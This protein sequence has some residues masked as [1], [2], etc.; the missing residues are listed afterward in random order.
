MFIA[1]PVTPGQG[2]ADHVRVSVHRRATMPARV[3]AVVALA[4]GLLLPTSIAQATPPV[5]GAVVGAPEPTP[6][7]SPGD[8]ANDGGGDGRVTFGMTTASGGTTD[9]R[10][11][12]AVN[13]PAGSVLND[14]VAVVNLSDA[15]LDVDLYAADVTNAED[16]SLDVA[17]RNDAKQL[18]GGWVTLGQAQVS[19]PGQSAATGPGLAMVPVTISIPKDAEPGDHLAAVLSSYTA[20][21]KPGAN[22]PAV[23]LEQR[24]G[25]RIYVTVQGDIRPGL[26]ISDVHVH[27]LAGGALGSGSMEVEYTLTNSGNV[28][29]GVNPSVR[30][31]GPFGL[32]PHSADGTA[33]AELL[34]HSSVTQ[35]VKLDGVYPLLLENVVVSATAVAALGAGDP[36]IGTVHAS[37]WMW[38]WSWQ[39]LLLLA[40]V[41]IV[42]EEVV[43]RR[44]KRRPGVW[45]PPEALWGERSPS[46][47]GGGTSATLGRGGATEPGHG[48]QAGEPIRGGAEPGHGPEREPVP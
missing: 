3:A 16:G 46:P 35:K 5:R 34:P 41:A 25:V 33:I 40:V 18:T 23:N 21:G 14:N 31:T 47:V 10:G 6:T 32:A 22:A 20:Q 9:D 8:T 43:R 4:T 15:P 12:I 19:L 1:R 37:A 30:A 26:T 39:I 2:A 27:F 17:G 11:F 28:R 13:A 36:Q 7:A 24:V 44:R 42:L 45:G 48:G 29:Y 38:L